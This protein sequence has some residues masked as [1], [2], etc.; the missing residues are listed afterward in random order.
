MRLPTACALLLLSVAPVAAQTPPPRPDDKSTAPLT[1]NQTDMRDAAQIEIELLNRQNQLLSQMLSQNQHGLVTYPVAM[2]L[3]G[4]I[5][6]LGNCRGT[7]AAICQAVRYPN[8]F[9][10]PAT[11][12]ADTVGAYVNGICFGP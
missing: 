7:V 5:N 2:P 6:C 12:P 9:V 3:P 4:P 10:Y 11:V 8:S 1:Q